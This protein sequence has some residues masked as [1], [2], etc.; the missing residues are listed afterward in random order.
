MINISGEGREYVKWRGR[1]SKD[2]TEGMGKKGVNADEQAAS[3]G[4][5]NIYLERSV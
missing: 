4:V 5:G 1:K 3:S 2:P